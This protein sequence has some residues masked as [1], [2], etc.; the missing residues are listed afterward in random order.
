M[1]NGRFDLTSNAFHVLKAG[2]GANR[3]DIA[4]LVEDADFDEVFEPQKI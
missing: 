3:S 4:E 2:Y 1:N